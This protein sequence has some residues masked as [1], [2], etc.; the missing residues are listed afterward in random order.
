[1]LC[2]NKNVW[3]DS[4]VEEESKEANVQVA[5]MKRKCATSRGVQW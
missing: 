5:G 1:M 4:P 3:A 2:L